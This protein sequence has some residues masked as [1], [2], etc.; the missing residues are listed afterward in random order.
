MEETIRI[1]QKYIL[2]RFS[3]EK[4]L[5]KIKKNLTS[6]Y[7]KNIKIKRFEIKWSSLTIT[8]L[9]NILLIWITI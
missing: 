6:K 2:Y 7:T 5:I 3:G 1:N 4:N 9:Q 8:A